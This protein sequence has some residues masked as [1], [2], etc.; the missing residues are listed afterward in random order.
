M[1]RPETAP[2]LRPRG[3]RAVAGVCRLLYR[4]QD[5]WHQRLDVGD[6]PE[7]AAVRGADHVLGPTVVPESTPQGLDP[8]G[9]CRLADESGAPDLGQQLLLS[10]HPVAF[11]DQHHQYVKHLWFD[12]DQPCVVTDLASVDVDHEVPEAVADRRGF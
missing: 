7:A 11:P 10:H 9:E 2:A 1:G 4:R 5:G 3:R 8:T 6:E 12:R